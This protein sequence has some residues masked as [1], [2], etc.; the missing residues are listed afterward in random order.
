[1]VTLGGNPSTQMDGLGSS[2]QSEESKYI[3]EKAMEE[4][5]FASEE[6]DYEDMGG[7]APMI[8]MALERGFNDVNYSH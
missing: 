6:A 5:V 8:F 4:Y 2:F 7:Q 1:M 3:V